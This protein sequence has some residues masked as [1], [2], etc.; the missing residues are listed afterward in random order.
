MVVARLG[1]GEGLL[2]KARGICKSWKVEEPGDGLRF[3]YRCEKPGA[4]QRLDTAAGLE[5]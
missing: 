4:A 1:E 5:T 3:L 2:G